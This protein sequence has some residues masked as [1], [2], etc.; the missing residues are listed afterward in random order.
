VAGETR[1]LTRARLGASL[2]A[3]VAVGACTRPTPAPGVP[4][5]PHRAFYYWRT[6]LRLSAPELSALQRL[7]AD[8][9]FVR[10]FDVEGPSGA[11]HI[12]APVD[13]AG[14][15]PAGI[16]VVPVVFLRAEVF[17]DAPPA[18]AAAL[19]DVVWSAVDG[20]ARRAAI[21]PRELQLDCDWTDTTRPAYFALLERLKVL[22]AG[23]GATTSATIRLHQIKYR[24]RTGVPPVARGMLMFYNMGELDAGAGAS[25]IFDAGRASRYLGR[26]SEY[27]LPLDAALPL[28]SWTRHLRGDRVVGLMQDTDPAE[29][30]G[31]DCLVPIGPGRFAASRTT[32]LHGEL[33]REG[34]VLATDE[35][36]AGVTLAAARLL[37]PE[38]AAAS[39]GG[40]TIA[41]FDLSER[42][43]RRH[44]PETLERVFPL[45]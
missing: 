31:V 42:S 18:A 28:F 20:L 5:S 13:M 14:P 4:A 27:P 24:E 43:L 17:R 41:L 30:T 11:A 10:F 23:A 34:D 22:A 12:V 16:E 38:L 37:A 29:L 7:R 21:H 40:R 8:R 15:V 9:L 36:D 6:S 35:T 39:P 19:A 1:T 44:E 3:L 26:I 45:F 2:A 33:L 32:F 25:S